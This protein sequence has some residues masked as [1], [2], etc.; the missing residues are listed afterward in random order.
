MI[1]L[2]SVSIGAVF[3]DFEVGDHRRIKLNVVY[4]ICL[5]QRKVQG[6]PSSHTVWCT[7]SDDHAL[8]SG[9]LL[10]RL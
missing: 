4:D 1:Q 7:F 8:I 3:D 5:I 9:L 2:L 6:T 10:L